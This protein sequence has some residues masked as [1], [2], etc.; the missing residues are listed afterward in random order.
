METMN[1][2]VLEFDGNEYT[3]EEVE[4]LNSFVTPEILE[5]LNE[6]KAE[7]DKVDKDGLE[8]VLFEN[9]PVVGTSSGVDYERILSSVVDIQEEMAKVMKKING[10]DG[11]DKLYAVYVQKK[12]RFDK[13]KK[14]LQDWSDSHSGDVRSFPW[15]KQ[16]KEV[17]KDRDEAYRAISSSKQSVSQLWET[18]KALKDKC[19]LVIGEHTY[20]WHLYFKLQDSPVEGRFVSGE[21]DSVDNQYVGKSTKID[22]SEVTNSVNPDWKLT[23]RDILEEELSSHVE[24]L[25]REE[26]PFTK[27]EL[28]PFPVYLN[29]MCFDITNE[30]KNMK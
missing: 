27:Q 23:D 22:E 5:V 30:Y 21:T 16:W 9:D 14:C 17:Q 18:W 20:V 1:N 12:N 26:A 8:K 15:W 6:M 10:C 2:N 13:A 29:G 3:L 28:I 24:E 19:S 25:L 7:K 4:L 11:N